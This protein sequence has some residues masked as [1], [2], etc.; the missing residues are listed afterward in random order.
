MNVSIELTTIEKI[1]VIA[2]RRGMTN[3]QLAESTNMTRQNLANKI[4][5][6][7][8][9]ESDMKKLAAALGCSLKITFVF[10]DTGEEI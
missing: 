8:L 6:G 7:D 3:T 2:D 4:S 5:R 10:N 1:K 9:R